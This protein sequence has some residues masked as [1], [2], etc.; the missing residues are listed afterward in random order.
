MKKSIT[1]NKT[2]VGEN[3]MLFADGLQNW[4]IFKHDETFIAHVFFHG[5]TIFTDLNKKAVLEALKDFAIP[6]AENFTI[7]PTNI[8]TTYTNCDVI[9]GIV[10]GET[11]QVFK[12]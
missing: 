11:K 12:Q 4:Y 1:L 10:D 9:Q 3:Y 2:N 7:K 6:E 5:E 8:E